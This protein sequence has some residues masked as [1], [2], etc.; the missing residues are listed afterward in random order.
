MSQ[1]A[2]SRS[3]PYKQAESATSANGDGEPEVHLSEA[4]GESGED[5]AEEEEEYEV[6]AILDH[7]ADGPGK[8]EYLISWVGYGPE[9]NTWEKQGNVEHARDIVE[10]YWK[11]VPKSQPVRKRGPGRTSTSSQASSSSRPAKQARTSR[12]NGANGANK[13]EAIDIHDDDDDE[14]AGFDLTHVGSVDKY[15]AVKDWEPLVAS[16]DT[17]ERGEDGKL[18]V[19][20]EMKG[21]EK[22]MQ[23][24]EVVNMRCPQ[25]MIAFYESRLKWSLT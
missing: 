18:V 11:K 24:A 17:I 14:K 8:F 22:V 7:R 16:I 9:H 5:G 25:K 3:S 13:G 19:Y 20:L 4:D 23:P 12:A 2:T 21:G 10:Q 6:K 1:R 15:I